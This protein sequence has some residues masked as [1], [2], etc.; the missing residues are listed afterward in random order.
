M[1]SP[2]PPQRRLW[3]W[4]AAL[5][6]L[7][8]AGF[9]LMVTVTEAPAGENLFVHR[10]TVRCVDLWNSA[11]NASARRAFGALGDEAPAS[12]AYAR[13]EPRKCLI[14]AASPAGDRA[15]QSIEIGGASFS[16]PDEVKPDGLEEFVGGWNAAIGAGGR[17]TLR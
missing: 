8:V 9:V 4:A 7:L 15:M 2:S 6:A 16:P 10:A 13:D 14:S 5:G 11:E 3:P 1:A 12:V 17:L